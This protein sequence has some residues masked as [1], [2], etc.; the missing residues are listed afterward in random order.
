M[1]SS[2]EEEDDS[3]LDHTSLLSH[4]DDRDLDEHDA[5]PN[6]DDRAYYYWELM[7]QLAAKPPRELG[8][9]ASP[10]ASQRM[11]P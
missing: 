6:G 5:I 7:K 4:D 1:P 10:R 2:D 11:G 3:T 8:H 9:A